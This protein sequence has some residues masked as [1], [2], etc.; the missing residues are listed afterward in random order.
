MSGRVEVGERSIRAMRWAARAPR[1]AL[2]LTLAVLCVAGLRAA[3]EGRPADAQPVRAPAGPDQPIGA[4]AEGFARA[5]LSFDPAD[6]ERREARLAPYL[7]RSMDA[8]AGLRI[9]G[10]GEQTVAWTA[11]VAQR[12]ERSGAT[13]TVAAETEQ[14]T[15]HLAVPVHRDGRGFLSV[16]S[17]PA[18][19]GA[20]ASDDAADPSDEEDVEDA[21]LRAVTERAVAN[22]LAGERRDLAADLTDG[23]V[24]SL[25]ARRLTV[26][27][28]DAVTWVRRGRRVAVAVQAEDEARNVWTLRYE[29]GV[30]RSGRWFVRSL[31]VD[32]TSKG[33][34][35]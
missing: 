18:L 16:S 2:Y 24:V 15:V 28:S 17:H 19:V 26:R 20:T 10:G 11:V 7:S 12:S 25:P 14:G 35:R 8:D 6:P 23:A 1:V 3:L 4:F 22:Y 33:G 21:G 32:P 34:L 5:Y 27:S 30:V 31:A 9:A 29:L 13:V